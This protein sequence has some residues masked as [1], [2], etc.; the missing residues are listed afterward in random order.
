L[1]AHPSLTVVCGH[2]F[3]GFEC[4]TFAAYPITTFFMKKKYHLAWPLVCLMAC[5]SA[6]TPPVVTPPSAASVGQALPAASTAEVS[7]EYLMGRFDPTTH[8]DFVRVGAAHTPKPAMLLRRE[9][10]E[11]FVRMFDAAQK[12]GVTLSIISSTRTFA[13]QKNI[14][15]GKW[16]RYATQHPDATDRALKI[17]EYSSMPGSS[18]HHW[19]TDIDLNDLNNRAFEGT[20]K[21]R[22]VYD[23]LVAHAAEYGFGQPYTPK[24]E[25]RPRGY[26]EEKWH[27]SYL[28]LAQPFRQQ[29]LAQLK[30]SD[31]SG[32]KGAE[33]AAAVHAV[34]YYVGGV[35][36]NCQ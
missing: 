1:K 26:N 27:W 35:A 24:G 14:W 5:Q 2:F 30:N 13:Q 8:P 19:G 16:E 36:Q 3:L 18:R 32:F 31:I 29:Y 21:H 12:D 28:P 6:T 22:K 34:E 4:R 23:W 20:G 11:A 25:A 7:T 9:A 10:Y 15:E 17:L 33:T